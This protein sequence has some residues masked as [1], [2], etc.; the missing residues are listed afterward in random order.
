MWAKD[1]SEIEAAIERGRRLTGLRNE[2]DSLFHGDAWNLDTKSLLLVLR[3]DGSSFFRRLGSRYRQA[4]ASFRAIYK[5]RP[6]KTL[7]ERIAL[8]EKLQ[9]A[10][11]NQHEYAR[12]EPLLSSALGPFWRGPGTS[13]NDAGILAAW[14]R[15]A[16]SEFGGARLIKL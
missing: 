4:A 14:A 16:L 9:I 6:P 11:E 3:S 2:I 1:L 13:W 7:K 8:V 5:N 15:V 12:I 10:Q